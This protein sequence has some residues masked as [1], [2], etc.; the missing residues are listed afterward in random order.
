MVKKYIADVK[1]NGNDDDNMIG[2]FLHLEHSW[3]QQCGWI[4]KA[5]PENVSNWAMW[6]RGLIR[7][8]ISSSTP[9]Y[10]FI[11]DNQY[12]GQ[13]LNRVW[14]VHEYCRLEL[15]LEPFVDQTTLVELEDHLMVIILVDCVIM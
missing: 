14:V 8:L 5:L 3:R 1:N 2:L 4:V 11:Q 6:R 12:D 7:I 13:N 15:I 9:C 10:L